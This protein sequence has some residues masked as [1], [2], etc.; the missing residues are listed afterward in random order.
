[1]RGKHYGVEQKVVVRKGSHKLAWRQLIT[2]MAFADANT[3]HFT[4]KKR[5]KKIKVQNQRGG[6]GM[7]ENQCE[8]LNVV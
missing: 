3:S 6:R 7:Y 8:G 5:Q 1:M 2:S 4:Q